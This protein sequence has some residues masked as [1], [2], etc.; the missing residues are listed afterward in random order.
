[1][2]QFFTFIHTRRPRLQREDNIKIG[3]TDKASEG[4]GWIH[5]VDS[6]GF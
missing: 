3:I 4:V 2:P 1:M 6:K 5:V